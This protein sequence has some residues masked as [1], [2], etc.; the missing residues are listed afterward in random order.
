MPNYIDYEVF[1]S[2]G[3]YY[4]AGTVEIPA[5]LCDIES[6]NGR[7]ISVRTW[8]AAKVGSMGYDEFIVVI[9]ANT[10]RVKRLIGH[11]ILITNLPSFASAQDRG[12]AGFSR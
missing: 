4:T 8:L 12:Y 3:R 9:P 5:V 2:D 11:A 10:D 1:E 7:H 6:D